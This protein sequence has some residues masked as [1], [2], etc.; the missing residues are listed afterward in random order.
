MFQRFFQS[1]FVRSSIIFS[2]AS[3]I[4]SVIGYVI[5]LLIARSFSLADYGEY[6][7]AMSYLLF[8]FVPI[9]TYGVILVKRLGKEKVSQRKSV[10][11]DL[12][13]WLKAELKAHAPL[14]LVLSLIF[15]VLVYFK[16]NL[17]L[18][19][20]IFVTLTTLLTLFQTTYS[21]SLQALKNFF[22]AGLFIVLIF[23]G[24]LF[25]S[26]VVIIV[27]PNLINIFVAF[28]GSTLFGLLIGRKML[29][30]NLTVSEEK[31][32]HKFLNV[33]SYLKR[34]DL[35][36]TLLTML[37][38]IG[39]A[40][41]DIILVKKFLPADQAGLYSSIS[42][43]GKIILYLATP[44]SQVAFAFFT[45][46]DS[47]H[48]SML[49]L[50]LLTLA[51]LGIGG[52]STGAYFF[53][54]ELVIGIIFGTKFLIISNLIWMAAI[55]GT[56]YSLISLYTQFFI[57]RKSNWGLLVFGASLIQGG[58]IF[59]NHNSLSQVIQINIIIS[60]LLLTA[61]V[62]KIAFSDLKRL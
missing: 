47:K 55:F 3:F 50:V 40:N 36:I 54:P 43:L 62:G 4:V 15:S 28:L 10:A 34:K 31:E 6:M 42:L 53:F 33:F 20:I 59:F 26:T 1:R 9:N 24:K 16:G 57:S 52:I 19:A 14:I 60:M 30:H 27:D 5:N 2:V 45:G 22:L 49:I 39:I 37:G 18:P 8:L 46:S 48:N 44:L 11:V 35:I 7:T 12:E 51:Y 21:A 13:R 25:L 38:L 61:L 23:V 32:T 17:G 41:V 58:L 56:L 29:H